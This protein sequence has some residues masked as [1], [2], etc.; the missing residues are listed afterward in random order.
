M[1]TRCAASV[2]VL[3]SLFNKIADSV[4]CCAQTSVGLDV[5]L[6]VYHTNG[7]LALDA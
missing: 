6:H 7:H 2:Q 3:G 5:A 4:G 1:A